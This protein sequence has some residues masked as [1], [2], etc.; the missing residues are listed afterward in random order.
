VI[1]ARNGRGI[2]WAILATALFAS[3][4]ATGCFSGGGDSPPSPSPTRFQV[5]TVA[6]ASSPTPGQPTPQPGAAPPSTDLAAANGLFREGRYG[7]ARAA[8]L[9][10]SSRSQLP[11]ER[12]EALVGAANAAFSVNDTA[13][14]LQALDQAVR[15]APS[16]SSVAVRAAY[17]QLKH[18]ND[19]GRTAEAASAFQVNRTI[20]DD[21]SLA[22]YFLHE[23][24]RALAGAGQFGAAE[25]LWQQVTSSGTASVALQGTIH[26]ARASI[27]RESHDDVALQK[28]LLDEIRATHDPAAYYESA[29]V[30]ERLGDSALFA[31]QL[32][33]LVLQVPSSHFAYL[34]LGD[35]GDAGLAIDAGA[36]GLVYYRKGLYSQARAVLLP[37]LEQAPTA[38]DLAFRAFYLA[39]SFEDAGDLA[40]AVKY[41]DVAAAS[42]A[43]SSAYVHRAKYWGARVTENQ[44]LPLEA[45]QR[46]VALVRDGPRGEFSEE[47]AFRAGYVLLNDGRTA[48]ALAVWAGLAASATP[49][50]EYWRGRAYARAGNDPAAR[51][52]Y[53][54]AVALGPYDLY[55]LEAAR[56]L[57]TLPALNVAYQPR[58]LA[59]PIDWDAIQSWLTLKLGGAPAG[60]KVTVACELMTAGLREAAAAEIYA[61]ADHAGEWRSFE[62]MREASQCGL[63]SV[64]AQLAVNLRINTGVASYEAP[65]DLLRVSY[66]I[67]FRSA[68]EGE[69]KKANVDPLFFAAL[70]RQESFWDPTAG[71]GAGA[72]G[73]TQVIPPTGEAIAAALGVSGFQPSDLYRPALSLEFGAYYLGGEIRSYRDPLVALAAYNAGPASAARWAAAGATSAADLVEVLDFLETQRY[74][75]LIVEAYAYY[76]LAW[77]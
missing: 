48:E 59:R 37:S 21:Q 61:A 2:A 3:A 63:T 28:A 44:L 58:N 55:G 9:S 23:G 65:K 57:G 7:E 51:A 32:R 29:E 26:R 42:G 72:L 27:A 31:Q 34:A 54:R 4:C 73:L 18:L 19:A 50:L 1:A 47:A 70:I 11:V 5:A 69:A 24:A 8:F 39:A 41:Y 75:T 25:A 52:S 67:D 14:G 13:A 76:Q 60:S 17:L 16:G 12:A 40:S 36:A 45:S 46:Y 77:S 71:S 15:A 6:P 22:P 20:A 35:L 43:S 62:L 74:V 64:A 38:G 66:P 10:L 49:R 68:V 30:A 56:A 33:Y 53:Q